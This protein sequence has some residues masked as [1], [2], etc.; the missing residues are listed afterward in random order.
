VSVVLVV[1]KWDAIEKDSHTLDQFRAMLLK[2][3]RFV[4]Y[5]PVLFISA[6]T[7]H[8]TGE[9]MQMALQ[10]NAQRHLRLSTRCGQQ[11]AARFARQ[12]PSADHQWQ[13]T[14]IMYG[15]QVRVAPP[16]FLFHVNEKIWCILA[17]RA[18]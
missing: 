7:G 8:R 12:T 5:A 11:I 3:L 1:N 2:H 10:V 6:K 18:F 4:D 15:T 14:Q 17:T 13:K 9:V 16:V